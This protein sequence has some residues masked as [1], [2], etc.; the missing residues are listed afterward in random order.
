MADRSI[1]KATTAACIFWQNESARAYAAAQ[2]EYK[3][4]AMSRVPAAQKRAAEFAQEASVRLSQLIG[5]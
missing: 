2:W 5:T 4:G 1:V 3:N